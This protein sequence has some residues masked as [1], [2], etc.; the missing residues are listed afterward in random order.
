MQVDLI[1]LTCA[2][3]NVP[4]FVISLIGFPTSFFHTHVPLIGSTC[5][6]A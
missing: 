3:A 4:K 6:Y 5:F 2:L 1:K